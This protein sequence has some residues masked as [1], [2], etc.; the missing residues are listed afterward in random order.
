MS[1]N[2]PTKNDR[3]A[4][5][6]RSVC[7]DRDDLIERTEQRVIARA[8]VLPPGY[9]DEQRDSE[10]GRERIGRLSIS[11]APKKIDRYTIP[12]A[13]NAYQCDTPPRPIN[14]PTP[15]PTPTPTTI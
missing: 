12:D 13:R 11:I 7:D 4:S 2:K 3:C 6:G 10:R 8:V 1:N 14:P 15:M 9:L 5:V